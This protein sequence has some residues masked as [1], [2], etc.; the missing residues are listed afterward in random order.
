MRD[1]DLRMRFSIYSF[2]ESMYCTTSSRKDKSNSKIRWGKQATGVIVN[3][4]INELM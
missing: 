2:C 3:K 4:D 1:D